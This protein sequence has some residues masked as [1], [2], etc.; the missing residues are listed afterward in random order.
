MNNRIYEQYKR[1]LVI[2]LTRDIGKELQRKGIKELEKMMI[3][4]RIG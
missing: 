2:K 4:R 3:K 1:G